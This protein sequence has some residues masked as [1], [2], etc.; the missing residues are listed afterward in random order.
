M[1]KYFYRLHSICFLILIVT[2][3]IQE[4]AT[5]S[6]VSS[7]QSQV[8]WTTTNRPEI[9][10]FQL[11]LAR[12]PSPAN[13]DNRIKNR[14]LPNGS[15]NYCATLNERLNQLSTINEVSTTT[16]SS[17]RM[18][19][20]RSGPND[21]PKWK[22]VFADLNLNDL[23]D[24]STKISS[25]WFSS[26]KKAKQ[27]ASRLYLEYL[28]KKRLLQDVEET[29]AGKKYAINEFSGTFDKVLSADI[30]KLVEARDASRSNLDY[31]TAD[32]IRDEL[33]KTYR[34]AVDDISRTWSVG[35]DFG[36]NGTFRWTDDGPINPRKLEKKAE[37]T[38][39]E[40]LESKKIEAKA[41]KE[42][43]SKI[44]VEAKTKTEVEAGVG[45]KVEAEAK[46]KAEDF[47]LSLEG[48]KL[49]ARNQPK[50]QEVE[51]QLKARYG[52]I[53]DLSEKAYTILFDLGMIIGPRLL[54]VDPEYDEL[55]N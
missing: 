38:S 26:K 16:F 5:F 50:S 45:P 40:E 43:E 46:D 21:E 15:L 51:A 33:W 24:K 20:I 19:Y 22:C 9:R 14:T 31:N 29:F 13:E 7:R 44:E 10:S 52:A 23:G 34:V 8:A 47:A 12:R 11:S 30:Q 37:S 18:T 42:G 54:I 49:E 48:K 39:S 27:N 41:E 6:A 35:G 53:E 55:T 32:E 36:P 17:E 1:L 25:D 4:G 2:S 28:D 3:T